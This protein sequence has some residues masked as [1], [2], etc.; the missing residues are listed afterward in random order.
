MNKL[1]GIVMGV[2]VMAGQ[3]FASGGGA[4]NPGSSSRIAGT[5][6]IRNTVLQQGVLRDLQAIDSSRRSMFR[7]DVFLNQWEDEAAGAEGSKY[8]INPALIFGDALEVTLLLPLHMS[9]IDGVEQKM[10]H[11][12]ADL[13][14]QANVHENFKIGLHGTYVRDQ[15]EEDDMGDATGYINAGG[16]ASI[17]VPLGGASLALGCVYDY[18]QPEDEDENGEDDGISTLIPAV[19]LGIP[20]NSSL[21]VNLYG[22]YY[23][24]LDRDLKDADY[25]DAGADL[26]VALGETWAISIGGKMAVG[27]DDLD[28]MEAYFGSEWRF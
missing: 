5:R 3:V 2:A 9:D 28:S 7:A 18:G 24:N 15:W 11:Y 10:Y 14:L 22:M 19:N 20:L 17:F 1:A 21:G 26:V 12:G 8:G 4:I 25:L 13:T 16:Y 23:Y 27:L 6:F